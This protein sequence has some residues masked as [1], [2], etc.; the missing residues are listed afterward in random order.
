MDILKLKIASFNCRGLNNEFKITQIRDYLSLYKIDICLLQETHFDSKENLEKLSNYVQ[1]FKVFC[2]FSETKTRGVGILIRDYLGEDENL[3]FRFFENGI[4]SLDIRINNTII[5]IVNIYAPNLRDEQ[6][7]F[8]EEIHSFLYDKKNVIFGGD[9]NNSFELESEK[10]L[11]K[12]WND[13]IKLFKL[14]EANKALGNE[15]QFY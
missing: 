11:E 6:L 7:K 15:K 13:L 2:P 4:I 5:S 12:K 3:E 10:I 1:N 8:I 9:F 14:E